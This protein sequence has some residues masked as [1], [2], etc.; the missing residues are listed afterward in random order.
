MTDLL[1]DNVYDL[2]IENGDFVAGESTLQHQKLLCATNKGEWREFPIMGVGINNWI[3]DE[4]VGSA[5]VDIK[6][7][8]ERDG[9]TVERISGTGQ[10]LKIEAYY[11]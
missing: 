3:K 8:F 7:Q 9:M 5:K 2:L 6:K 11:E 4:N 1:V 10:T